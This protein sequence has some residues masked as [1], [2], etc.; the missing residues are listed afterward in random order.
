MQQTDYTADNA[1]W[2]NK[3][4]EFTAPATAT[5]LRFELRTYRN[6][7]NDEFGGYIYYDDMEFVEVK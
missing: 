3:V 2:Q 1:D 4:I 7:S 5:K 6:M